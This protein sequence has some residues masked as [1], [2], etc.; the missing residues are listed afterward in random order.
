[1]NQKSLTGDSGSEID[2]A[3]ASSKET[4]ILKEELSSGKN[5]ADLVHNWDHESTNLKIQLPMLIQALLV[6]TFQYR[7]KSFNL[8]DSV[9]DLKS[10]FT[11]L[12]R[13]KDFD[14]VMAFTLS[15]SEIELLNPNRPVQIEISGKL[16]S[17][18]LTVAYVKAKNE[19]NIGYESQILDD[20][21]A[22]L[23]KSVPAHYSTLSSEKEPKAN[24]PPAPGKPQ[25]RNVTPQYGVPVTNELF[26][27][28]NVEAWH[29]I[30]E[31]YHSSH[32][33]AQ[34]MI[35]HRGQRVYRIYSLFGWGKIKF[36]DA[37]FF[38]VAGNDLRDVSKLKKYLSEA[39]SPRF[40]PYIKKNVNA[41]LKLF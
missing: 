41:P 12:S 6:D 30:I 36:G 19:G 39:A 18:K 28:G 33:G 14:V 22:E 35:F 11:K 17:R 1:M 20:I 7:F 15:S 4:T 40:Q 13:L 23:L 37:I 8:P 25:R 31:S 24:H 32:P 27:Y 26:H 16:L 5:L 29:N 21:Q 38:A 34:V 3:A 10:A 9:P 2:K